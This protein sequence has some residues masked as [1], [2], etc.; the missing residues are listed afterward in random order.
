MHN[1]IVTEEQIKNPNWG[2]A[3]PGAGR[4]AELVKLSRD[5]VRL[6]LGGLNSFRKD[7]PLAL[8]VA[9]LRAFTDRR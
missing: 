4:R 9:R 6:L 2:G 7:S 1:S 5:E 8:L 3:R